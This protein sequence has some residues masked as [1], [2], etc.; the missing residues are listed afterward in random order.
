M[1][2]EERIEKLRHLITCMKCEV[3][4]KPCDDNCPT[5][6]DAGNTG[7]IIENLEEIAKALEQ[8]P[9][10]DAISR[11][12]VKAEYK[13]RLEESLIDKSRGIDLSEYANCELFNKFIDSLPS[14]TPQPKTGHWIPVSERLPRASEIVLLSLPEHTMVD[15]EECSPCVIC[16]HYIGGKSEEWGISDG[17][18][19]GYGLVAYKHC[20]PIAWMPLPEP[21]QRGDENDNTN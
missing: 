20:K 18:T 2:R 12:L 15:G 5:Q 9:C 13:R 6:Y 19:V 14:I 16:G 1:T 7:E 8:E 3:S 4:G 10:E 17:T 21:Y 11:S